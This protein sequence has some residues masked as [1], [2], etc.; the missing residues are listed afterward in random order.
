MGLGTE[1]FN[2]GL[3]RFGLLLKNAPE[4]GPH[5]SSITSSPLTVLARTHRPW[6]AHVSD[7]GGSASVGSHLSLSLKGNEEAVAQTAEERC[8]GRSTLAEEHSELALFLPPFP[9]RTSH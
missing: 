1:E 4:D 3:C 8:A 5:P 7:R 9:A 6:A 2:Q